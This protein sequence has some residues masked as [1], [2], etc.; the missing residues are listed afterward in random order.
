[1]YVNTGLH[2]QTLHSLMAVQDA[3]V[4]VAILIAV[5]GVL[6]T[7][8]ELRRKVPMGVSFRGDRGHNVLSAL[9][10]YHGPEEETVLELALNHQRWLNDP[11][12]FWQ[13]QSVPDFSGLMPEAQIVA[14]FVARDRSDK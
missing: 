4:L 1:M 11:P 7:D 13:A 9:M 14:G 8:E 3:A 6:D 5:R 2:M 10:R 12:S